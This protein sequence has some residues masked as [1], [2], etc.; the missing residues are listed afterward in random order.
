[1]Y[2][3][4]DFPAGIDPLTG[5]PAVD[6]AMLERRPVAVKIQMFPRGQRPPWGIS[7]ADIVYDYYQ[8]FGLTRLHALFYGQNA[9]TVGPI[10]SARLLD[11]D[12]VSMY[13]SIFAFGSAEQRTYS[14]LFSKDFS[15]RLVVEGGASC[16]PMCRVEPDSYNYLVAN[17]AELS[18][19]IS[20]KGVD[21][22]RPN[23]DGMSFASALPSGGQPMQQIS[24]RY[25]ISSYARW[26]YDPASGRYLRSQDV[27]EAFDS[28]SEVYEPLVDRAN[29][30]QIAADNVVILFA[31]HQ[32]TFNT[33]PGPN[34]VVEIQL[35]G[36]GDGY[37]F[38]DGQ[39]YQVTWNR[40]GTNT[41]V[42]LSLP[43]GTRY[44]FKPGTTWF[45]VVGRTTKI[46]NSVAGVIRFVNGIP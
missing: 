21:N 14:R 8:N 41:P 4:A 10:R 34:E 25:S 18:K 44:A 29:N 36:S 27:Q 19:Y 46:E 13:N 40:P 35:N 42:F 7:Q 23:L 16:P 3:P 26:D 31:S 12:L 15:T 1:M 17:T 24:V 22:A 43:D 6:A 11:I 33:H 2:G 28:A 45:Q 30:Q 38:R 20:G 5:K 37:A 39:V 9:E 32:Y